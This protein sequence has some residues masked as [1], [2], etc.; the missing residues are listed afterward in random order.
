MKNH[1]IPGMRI[2]FF[3]LLLLA[4]AY[5]L[6]VWL[7]AQGLDHKGKGER[8]AGQYYK[9]I[10]QSFTEDRY[11]WS[12]PSAVQ[13]NAA[14]SGGSNKAPSNEN[15]LAEVHT[16][17]DTFLLRNPGLRAENVPVE[18][19]TASGSGLDPHL[20]VKAATVQIDRVAKARNL[21]PEKLRQLVRE[22]TEKPLLGILGPEK[23]HVLQLNLA[24]D[25][26]SLNQ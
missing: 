24:L 11:F 4:I 7:M 20:S 2:T 15:Y 12:R 5:P 26:L 22:H 21:P 3:C 18:L 25:E 14:G 9:Q 19:I 17:L 1:L 16:R 10:G 6:L 13:Y 8:T 23:I